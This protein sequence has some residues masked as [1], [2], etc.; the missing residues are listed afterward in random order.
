MNRALLA[1]PCLF[2]FAVPAFPADPEVEPGFRKRVVEGF[3][4]HVADDIY[5]IDAAKYRRAPF[6]VLAQELA[7]MARVLTPRTLAA[8]REKPVWVEWDANIINP[9]AKNGGAVAYYRPAD[10]RTNAPAW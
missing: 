7:V 8:V 3:T 2:A 4:L 6:D 10:Q 5:K 9:N 1:L